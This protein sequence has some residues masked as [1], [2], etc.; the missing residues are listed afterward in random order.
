MTPQA[1]TEYDLLVE[2]TEGAGAHLIGN[3]WRGV[4]FVE[5]YQHA[6]SLRSDVLVLTFDDL[7]WVLDEAE[8]AGLT[9][10]GDPVA[11][12]CDPDQSSLH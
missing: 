4:A 5:H 7:T 3:S 2:V 11:H 8:E 6:E 10:G 12:L 1:D 9:I